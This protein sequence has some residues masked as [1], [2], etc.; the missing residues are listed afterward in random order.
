MPTWCQLLNRFFIL[1]MIKGMQRFDFSVIAFTFICMAI[2]IIIC[3]IRKTISF[4]CQN[5]NFEVRAFRLHLQIYH[6]LVHIFCFYLSRLNK[7][8]QFWKLP[9]ISDSKKGAIFVSYF[10]CIFYSDFESLCC[11]ILIYPLLYEQ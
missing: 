3:L 9:C 1:I 6:S 4:V 10:T 5:I 11:A 2:W 8:S 7:L